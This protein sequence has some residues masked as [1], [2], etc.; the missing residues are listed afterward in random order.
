MGCRLWG[1]T[2]LDTTEATKQQHTVKG[3][4]IVNKAEIDVVST[5]Y[6]YSLL[7]YKKIEVPNNLFK[8]TQLRSSCSAH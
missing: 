2:E 6:Y 3:L 7:I 5:Y 1:R 8:V 4:G